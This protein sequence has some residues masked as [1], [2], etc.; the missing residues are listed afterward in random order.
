[1]FNLVAEVNH[2]VRIML[3]FIDTELHWQ[4]PH[5]RID[6]C[7]HFRMFVIS[8]TFK[9]FFSLYGI[10]LCTF[11]NKTFLFLK[12]EFPHISTSF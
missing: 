8:A 2:E 12:I 3:Y 1:M 10:A 11:L 7:V 4:T 5:I 9:D 6:Y